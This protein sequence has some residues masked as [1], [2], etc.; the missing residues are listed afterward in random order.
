MR[1]RKT[2]SYETE[3]HSPDLSE[4]ILELGRMKNCPYWGRSFAAIAGMILSEYVPKE[5][6][7]YRQQEGKGT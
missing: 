3:H 7:K 4:E 2:F 5:I 6:E 1:I